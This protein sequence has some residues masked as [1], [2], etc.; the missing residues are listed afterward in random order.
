MEKFPQR[1]WDTYEALLAIKTNNSQKADFEDLIEL[2]RI[3][4]NKLIV[5][6]FCTFDELKK[7]LYE[8]YPA[9]L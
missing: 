7:E 2:K 4:N 8:K 3:E 9:T 6:S 5:T 1:C